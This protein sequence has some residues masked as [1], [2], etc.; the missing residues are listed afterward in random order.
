MQ[1]G[2]V[3]WRERT[4]CSCMRMKLVPQQLQSFISTYN[5]DGLD[6]SRSST[7]PRWV[8]GPTCPTRYPLRSLRVTLQNPI[9]LFYHALSH[10]FFPG[11]QLQC[12]RPSLSQGRKA[13]RPRL[14]HRGWLP[15]QLRHPGK[16]RAQAQSM[17]QGVRLVYN[18]LNSS[19]IF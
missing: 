6:G 17:A 8:T 3:I 16:R 14:R 7:C 19:L 18:L 13:P 11:G 1:P 9:L 12:R 15:L 5:Y 2:G 10:P 4:C